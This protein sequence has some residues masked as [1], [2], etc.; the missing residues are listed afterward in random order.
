MHISTLRIQH[1]AY[2]KKNSPSLP[3][4]LITQSTNWQ[5]RTALVVMPSLFMF[6]LASELKVAHSVRSNSYTT[7]HSLRTAEWAEQQHAERAKSRPVNPTESSSHITDLYRQSIM[8][9]GVRIV[10]GNRLG[11][12]HQIMNYWQENPVKILAAVGLPAVA[13][14]FY[15]KSG[16][17][18]L[19]LQQK[20]MHTRV[21]G[22]G[23]VVAIMLA[24]MGFKDYMDKHGKFITEA[25]ADRR[26]EEMQ[27]MRES[28]LQR[29]AQDHQFKLER[30]NE[31]KAAHDADVAEGH[32]HDSKKKLRK[33]KKQ[34]EETDSP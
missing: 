15:G 12:H 14:I 19:Q 24:L 18:Q 20:I 16:Q 21:L 17:S 28:L 11:M 5:S 4:I 6:A 1:Q 34:A 25:E 26:V 13:Y 33:H 29:L 27:M 7:E 9:S 3:H 10:P 2:S 32:A 31:L 22:Q 8:S 23:T 30:Q